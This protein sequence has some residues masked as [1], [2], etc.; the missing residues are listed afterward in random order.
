[1][2]EVKIWAVN[3]TSDV[4]PLEAR[5]RVDTES[6]LEETLVNNP[7]LLLPGLRLVG[8]QTPTD[9]GPLDL[10]GVDQD[11][12]LVV[13][14]LKRGTLSREAV[15]QV[16][17]YASYLEA[18]DLADLANHISESSG[19]HGIDAIDDFQEWYGRGLESL[20]PLR[21]FLVGLGADDRTERM[22]SFLVNNSGMDIS[23]L[24]FH[25]FAYDGKT[26]L[27]KQELVEGT[28]D[29]VRHSSSGYLSVADRRE[30]LAERIEECGIAQ[31]FD[32]VSGMFRESWHRPIEDPAQSRLTFSLLEQTE[33]GSRGQRSYARIAPDQRS[34]RII[35]YRRAINLCPDKFAQVKPAIRFETYRDL[36]DPQDTYAELIFPL[37]SAGWETHKERLYTLTQAVYEAWERRGQ[38]ETPVAPDLNHDHQT[39]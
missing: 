19:E 9:G 7:Q 26:L 25:G 27:A 38:G 29:I 22:V 6:L 11:G 34:I 21:M 36:S 28:S 2:E 13:F 10:L 33:S 5:D 24:T 30:Q 18:M 4:V 15:A 35:F 17:D 16:I 32:A 14:E 31:L 12:K 39:V 20:K 1:M 3:G 23:L 8:R 37:D